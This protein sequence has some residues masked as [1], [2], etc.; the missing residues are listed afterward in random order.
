MLDVVRSHG[1]VPEEIYSGKGKTAND[2][3]L[4][5]SILYD[6]VWEARTSASLRFI[7]AVNCYDIIENAIS[8]LVFQAFGVPLEAVESMLT[9]IKEIKY[10]L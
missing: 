7:D 5:K 2:C 3:S 4:A 9:A 1:F 8:S 6:I 10:F